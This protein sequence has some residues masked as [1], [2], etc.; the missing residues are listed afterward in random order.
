MEGLQSPAQAMYWLV[1]GRVLFLLIHLVGTGCFAYIVARRVQPLLRAQRDNRFD[2]PGLRLWNVLQFWFG[3]WKHPRYL[4]P[5]ILHILVFA[6]FLLL[7][8]RAF[9]LILGISDTSLLSGTAAHIY[10]TVRCYATTVVFLCMVIAATRRLVFKP[11]RYAVPSQ[12]GKAHTA[13]AIFLLGLIAILML[14]DSTYEASQ[15]AAQAQ[16]G[17][18]DEFLAVLSLPWVLKWLLLET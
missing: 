4:G 10:D 18:S 16:Q 14:A 13:D 11:A 5:G 7:A 6:G 3:Q 2:R 12:F 1:P 17:A 9:S 8:T 15:A